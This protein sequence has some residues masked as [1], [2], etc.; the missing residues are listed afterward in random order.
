MSTRRWPSRP[1]R[2]GTAWRSPKP[3]AVASSLAFLSARSLHAD[4]PVRVPDANLMEVRLPNELNSN[5][6]GLAGCARVW[7][8]NDPPLAALVRKSVPGLKIHRQN[9]DV[10]GLGHLAFNLVP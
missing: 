3:I 10:R 1:R 8:P 6:S 7:P 4:A 2:A 5:A 9:A